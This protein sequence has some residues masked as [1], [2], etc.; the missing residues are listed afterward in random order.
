MGRGRLSRCDVD[1]SA[2][3]SSESRPRRDEM[4]AP[5]ASRSRPHRRPLDEQPVARRPAAR[6]PPDPAQDPKPAEGKPAST[7]IRGAEY[8]RILD[9]LRVTFRIKAPDAQKVEFGF[10]DNKRYAAT[11]G[12]DGFWTATTD[13]VVPGFHYYRMFID[14]VQVN[15]PASQTFYGTGKDTSGIEVPEKGVDTTCRRTSRTARSASAGTSRRRP[16]TGGAFSSTPLPA[17]T[18]TARRGIP[19]STSSTAAARTRPA[20]RI[21]A[22]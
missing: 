3:I 7:N 11:K 13:P 1:P 2:L 8:P 22:A 4:T 15:D 12:E 18:P 17:T 20:G 9:D 5:T 19:S 6:V 21:R 14:G 16:G 10:F